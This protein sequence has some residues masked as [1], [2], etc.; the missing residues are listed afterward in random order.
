MIF[1]WNMSGVQRVI[2]RL[3]WLIAFLAVVSPS[4]MAVEATKTASIDWAKAREWWA[5]KAPQKNELPAVS[6]SAWPSQRID[7][8][9]LAR[10][11]SE[12]LTPSPETTKRILARRLYLDLT[13][14]P[15]TPA[16]MAAFLS[17]ENGDAYERLAEELMQRRAFG[18]RLASM[19]LNNVRYAEDQAHQVGANTAFFYPNAYR[20]R[21]WVI[22]AFNNDV[23]YD[24]FIRKQ[25]AADLIKDTP[26]GDLPALGFIGL[27]HK[28]YNRGRLDVKAEEWAEQVD[29]LT[30][31][32]LGLTVAC[33]QCHD[34]KYDAFTQKDYYAL[35]GVFASTDLVDRMADGSK[36]KKDTEA[37]KKRIDTIHMVHDKK[38]ENLHVFLRGNPETKGEIVPRRFLRVLS[39]GEPKPFTQGTGR[40]ELAESIVSP[41]NPLTARVIVN[42]V[43]LMFFG[44]GLVTTPS[45][46]GL[47]GTKPSHPALLDDLAVRFMENG[48]S[49]KRLIREMVLS[50]TYRQRSDESEANRAIDP[51]NTHLWRMNRRRLS[52]EQWR[53]SILAAGD[54]LERT[55]GKSLELTD[56]KNVRRTVYARVSRKKLNDMLMQFD[57]PDPNVHAAKRSAT[58]T[59]MQKLFVMNN[60]FMIEQAKR[61]AKRVTGDS[62][63]ASAEQVQSIYDI[64]Y[65]RKPSAAELDLALRF[66]QLPAESRLT[67]W[68]QYSHAL[69]AANEM[70]Y[71]D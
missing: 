37:A 9:I 23:P 53:D 21:E 70:S 54:N 17:D 55:G 66:L 47:L 31:S 13:G 71:I 38:P 63:D 3:A 22:D 7:H 19:W 45:N 49:M 51:G 57:Y 25:L 15:P 10:L 6:N 1:G 39:E 18:E 8:F 64:L 26:T 52:I 29:T 24:K 40:L 36:I 59:A 2:G 32:L 11:D 30:R 48:W 60:R 67:R 35:A 41:D 42:R 34:H 56:K 4:A 12:Q 69:L 14:L 27:G 65:N 46:F 68:E 62:L 58:T 44:R 33:A 50:S 28:Y 61:L 16:E 43:W 5:Y 20:Y